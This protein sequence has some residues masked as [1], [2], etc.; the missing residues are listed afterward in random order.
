[1]SEFKCA[2]TLNFRWEKNQ[3]KQNELTADLSIPWLPMIFV[4]GVFQIFF[5][6]ISYFNTV[7]EIDKKK[8]KLEIKRRIHADM[9]FDSIYF[10]I[11]YTQF[12]S[13]SMYF[14]IA[15]DKSV[16]RHID[17]TKRHINPSPPNHTLTSIA[18]SIA[19]LEFFLGVHKRDVI[20]GIN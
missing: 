14:W 9:S 12:C 1:M 2:T 20:N 11:I 17:D 16:T 3:T 19:T 7:N 10:N 6:Q 13:H 8:E 18:E 4:A 15:F 5:K